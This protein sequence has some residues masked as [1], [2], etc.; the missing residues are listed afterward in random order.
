MT[1]QDQKT[2]KFYRGLSLCD[3]EWEA[4]EALNPVLEVSLALCLHFEF[5]QSFK[6]E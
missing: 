2:N 5:I 1:S 3:E 4:V 6:H